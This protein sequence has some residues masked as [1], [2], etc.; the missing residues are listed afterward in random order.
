VASRAFSWSSPEATTTTADWQICAPASRASPAGPAKCE[1]LSH[2]KVTCNPGNLF[3]RN[4]TIKAGLTGGTQTRPGSGRS[5]P[6]PARAFHIPAR[7]LLFLL[8]KRTLG[9]LRNVTASVRLVVVPRRF[10]PAGN[11]VLAVPPFAIH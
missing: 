3:H 4:A 10:A 1:R 11:A 9:R 6:P 2:V 8:V 5:E 7:G